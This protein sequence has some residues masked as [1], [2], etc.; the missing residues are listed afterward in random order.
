MPENKD[1]SMSSAYKLHHMLSHHYLLEIRGTS[2]PKSDCHYTTSSWY[3][4]SKATFWCVEISISKIN[5][6]PWYKDRI[7]NDKVMLLYGNSYW[8]CVP[9]DPLHLK[10]NVLNLMKPFYLNIMP[11][12]VLCPHKRF[13]ATRSLHQKCPASCSQSKWLFSTGSLC[14]RHPALR[15]P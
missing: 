4:H 3:W 14:Q 1:L 9:K 6:L 7:R 11:C 13:P 15:E 10:Y 12:T 2:V 8:K 5:L